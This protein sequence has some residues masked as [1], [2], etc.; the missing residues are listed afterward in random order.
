MVKRTT[1]ASLLTIT[2]VIFG[3]RFFFT[4]NRD[5]H[6]LYTEYTVCLFVTI[7]VL[8]Y[9]L[10]TEQRNLKNKRLVEYQLKKLS[11]STKITLAGSILIALLSIHTIYLELKFPLPDI[12]GFFESTPESGNLSILIRIYVLVV[13][14]LTAIRSALVLQ[15]Y[16]RAL[17][18]KESAKEDAD[19]L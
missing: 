6:I 13:A 14:I 4:Y 5:G 3:G 19:H 15:M 1:A 2:L 18:Q 12:E 7:G 10:I 11:L 8:L 16:S 17:N 9:G